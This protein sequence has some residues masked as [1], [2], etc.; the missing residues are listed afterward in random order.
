M[1]TNEEK[2]LQEMQDLN[3]AGV[4]LCIEVQACVA[5]AIIAALQLACRHPQ[6]PEMTRNIVT[7]V[8]KEITDQLCSPGSSLYSHLQEGFEKPIVEMLPNYANC[9]N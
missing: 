7:T 2:A 1:E 4:V 5:L 8:A 3:E 9:M 6:V